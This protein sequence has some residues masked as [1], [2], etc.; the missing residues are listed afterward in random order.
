MENIVT[1]VQA[2]LVVC[3]L[4]LATR[5]LRREWRGITMPLRDPAKVLTFF[6]GFRMSVIGLALIGIALGWAFGQTWLLLIA[7]AIGIEETIESTIDIFALTRGKDLRLG[8]R[9][10]TDR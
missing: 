9:P 8:P 6:Q 3:G 7:I 10:S 4:F 1:A 2:L 5:G